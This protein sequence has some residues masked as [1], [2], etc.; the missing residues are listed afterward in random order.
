MI[1]TLL[2]LLL[3]TLT[4]AQ[5]IRID[6][7]YNLLKNFTRD[8]AREVVIDRTRGFEWQDDKSV[9]TFWRDW[10]G[11]ID[12][13]EAL[14]LAGY[15]DWR[16]P[17][18][19]EL[20]SI[21]TSRGVEKSFVNGK[22]GYFWS[23][24]PVMGNARL[25]WDVSFGREHSRSDDVDL[26]VFSTVRCVRNEQKKFVDL[27]FD[28][29]VQKIIDAKIAA[30]PAPPQE[31]EVVKDMFETTS[32][33]EA[34]VMRVKKEQAQAQKTYRE[35]VT[36]VMKSAKTEGIKQALEISYGR[37]ILDGVLY[38]AE[39]GY[40]VGNLRFENKSD[41]G[42]Q[43]VAIAVPRDQARAMYADR[44]HLK[45][46]AVFDYDGKSVSLSRIEVPYA[47]QT[48]I[49]KFADYN[50]DTT[51]VAVN[52]QNSPLD[53][54]TPTTAISV[55]EG[56]MATLDTSRLRSFDDLDILLAKAPKAKVDSRKWL[57]VIGIES[58]VATASILY[59]KRSAQMFAQTAQKALGVPTSNSYVL[60]DGDA[61]AQRI[62]TTLLKLERSVKKGDTVYFYY[63]GHGIPVP[64]RDNAPFMLATDM[65][66]SYVAQEE[67]FALERIYKALTDTQASKVI[68]V[69]D[70]CF[71]GGSDGKSIH[72]TGVA[73]PL[74]R[75]K[76]VSFDKSKMALLAAGSGTQYS[77]AYE[78]KGHR[79]FSYFV[80]E[81]LLRGTQDIATLFKSA[82]ART[83]DTSRKL[84]GELREQE[85]V[86]EGN[87][88]LEL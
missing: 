76:S 47:K 1:R 78:Q 73:A 32:E 59:A 63:N 2:F 77:N 61:T 26:S 72:G 11:A 22:E 25:A 7:P 30:I 45:P 35:Q 23:V 39:N 75:A 9:G 62:K 27:N 16:L 12:Y 65:E 51:R 43:K 79:L 80:M 55:E 24:S 5:E 69:V 4:S 41:F 87:S 6:S 81:E 49:A 82:R 68:A 66:P 13:C 20:K 85:P 29:M 33:F 40:F 67:F 71:S 8:N 36:K 86:I 14:S 50:I 38:N 46:V 31:I 64:K 70:S 19:T 37:P 28:E 52:I 58:Y 42:T 88:K 56:T 15:D 3:A 60:I 74:L 17:T 57:V 18:I 48:Y 53:I 83:Y 84:Y 54:A 21:A 34:R 44:D 10:Q